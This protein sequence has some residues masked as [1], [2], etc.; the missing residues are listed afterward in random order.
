MTVEELKALLDRGD[1][2]VVLDVRE[3]FELGIARYP[4]EVVH[5]PLGS[6]PE[7][8]AEIP[9]GVPVVCACRSGGR[10]AQAVRFLRS[11]G[12]EQAVNLEGGILAWSSRIDPGIPQY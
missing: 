6:L 11:R 8:Y 2:P 12:Y 9:A 3:P 7:R 4:M 1:V 5:I 10:S